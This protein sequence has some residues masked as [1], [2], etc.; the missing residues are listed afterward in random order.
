MKKQSI[1]L[2]GLLLLNF[3]MASA[4]NTYFVSSSLGDDTNNGL[5]EGAPWQSLSKV[6]SADL[7]PGDVVR[8][9]RADTFYGQLWPTYSG[10]EGQPILFTDYGNANDP[11]PI[12]SGSGGP[13]GDYIATIQ[14]RNKEYLEFSNLEIRNDRQVTRNGAVAD[15]AA[16]GI[17]VQNTSN[18]IMHGFKFTNLTIRKIYAVDIT[19]FLPNDVDR[20]RIAGIYFRSERNRNVGLEKNIQ[21]V[22]VENCFIT[23][24]GKL[25]VWAQHMGANAGVGNDSINR[26]KNIVIRNNHFLHTGGACVTIGSSYN[27]LVENNI[28]EYPGSDFA[29]DRMTNRGSGAWFFNGRHT[30][31]QHNKTLHARGFNDSYGLHID[32]NNE[33]VILQYNYS[34]D[35]AGFVEILGNNLHATYRYNISVNDGY[36]GFKGNTFWFSGFVGAGN[37]HINSVNNWVY[38]NSIYIG[39]N[40]AGGVL[41]P[42]IQLT[43]DESIIANNAIYVAGGA[44]LGF[45]TLSNDGSI[46][47]DN[48]MYYG[49]IKW[50]NFVGNDANRYQ[51]NPL[52]LNPGALNNA[53]A[54]K[55]EVGSPA[56]GAGRALTEPLFPMAGKGIFEN[57]TAKAEVDYYGNPV[58][59]SQAGENIGAYNGTGEMPL[60]NNSTAVGTAFEAEDAVL[61]GTVERA[62]CDFASDEEIVRSISGGAG[63]AVTFDAVNV[64]NAG[65]Y[66]L[67]IEYFTTTD[68]TLTYELNGGAAQTIDVSASSGW[69]FAGAA[70]GTT[71]IQIA[72]N[73]GTNNIKFYN[74]PI[75]DR[76]YLQA[77]VSSGEWEAEDAIRFGTAGLNPCDN[78]SG[79]LA[80]SSL[81]NGEVNHV[82]FR[83]VY[84]S[85]TDQYRLSISYL[86][87]TER[88]MNVKVNGV[89]EQ[90]NVCASGKWCAAGG[91][92]G[93]Y[94]LVVNLNAGFNEV[95]IFNAPLIDKIAIDDNINDISTTNEEICDSIDNDCDGLIDEGLE[96]STWYHDQDND[97]YGN[98][99]TAIEDCKAPDIWHVQIGGDCDDTRDIVNPGADEICDQLDNDCD[100]QVNEGINETFYADVDDDNFGDNNAPTTTCNGQPHG[101][102]TDNTD[103]DDND[104]SINPGADEI[105]GNNIDDNCN[106]ETDEGGNCNIDGANGEYGLAISENGNQLIIDWDAFSN[107][108]GNSF[109]YLDYW[110]NGSYQGSVPASIDFGQRIFGINNVS[111]GSSVEF[112]FKYNTPYGQYIGTQSDHSYTMGACAGAAKK[113]LTEEVKAIQL[114]PN[115][116]TETINI[117][118]PN[119]AILKASV[120]GNQGLLREIQA[121]NAN[122]IEIQ[123]S[124]LPA[125][126]Y[127]IQLETANGTEVLKFTKL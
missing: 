19:D 79:G 84:V 72:L 26:N 104:A 99:N 83:D 116:A 90:L 65:T 11:L 35:N 113:A 82:S 121:E 15:S 52:Y 97:S 112:F 78:F 68:R 3:V 10:V 50:N 2:L 111:A 23:E 63:N 13:G 7:Q 81:S 54:Y 8:F 17:Y 115:P 110:I 43:A 103:C 28:F 33:Y 62:S 125:G 29:G 40:L 58:D 57:I 51:A 27:T 5:S 21:D 20:V 4:Q 100:G 34:E 47:I 36:R 126:I 46:T 120:I 1:I 101:T 18:S 37:D 124:E 86:T 85:N 31:V 76:I 69:C 30:V 61:S 98:D 14:I 66:N 44:G 75:L 109:C 38:N 55:L 45:D 108:Y 96:Y 49:N 48:N 64:T 87:A 105:P 56:I 25:G 70:P 73:Q 41:M 67:T 91:S 32:F 42:D 107:G 92:P 117:Q 80:V 114:T 22:L 39:E 95:K 93:V 119:E 122:A 9:A 53:D 118:S 88:G 89:P 59:L 60:G 77:P 6:G 102:V 12:I 16:Y 123:V 71:T 127:S 24:T 94:Q 106:G 74:S